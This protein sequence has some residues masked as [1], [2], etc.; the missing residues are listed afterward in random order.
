LAK[1]SPRP[2]HADAPRSSR[3][4]ALVD[5]VGLGD[6]EILPATAYQL[7]HD[8]AI[9][10]ARLNLATFV[11][12]FMGEHADKI[13]SESFDKNVIDYSPVSPRRVSDTSPLALH[14]IMNI[15]VE[16]FYWMMISAEGSDEC[17]SAVKSS[18]QRMGISAGLC[19]YE[20]ALQVSQRRSR[21]PVDVG[22]C[23]KFA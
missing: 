20:S 9:R 15:S 19:E 11:G 4:F 22:V 7:V 23:L 1:P 13:Y 17:E 16:V 18:S 6:E 2:T 5:D 14:A 21:E 8:E 12:T 10:N 3:G